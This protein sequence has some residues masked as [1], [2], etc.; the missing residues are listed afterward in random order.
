MGVRQVRMQDQPP[1][2]RRPKDR[3]RE[4]FNIEGGNN[5]GRASMEREGYGFNM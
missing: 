3:Q 5:A 1:T 4:C 2:S